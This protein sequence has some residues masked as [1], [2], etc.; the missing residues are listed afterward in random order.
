M[1]SCRIQTSGTLRSHWS[2]TLP[3]RCT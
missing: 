1:N 3:S 2:T